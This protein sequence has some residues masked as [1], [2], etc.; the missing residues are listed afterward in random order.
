MRIIL[1]FKKKCL[2]LLFRKKYFTCTFNNFVYFDVCNLR[3]SSSYIPFRTKL[4]IK[5]SPFICFECFF[6]Y[7]P[8]QGFVCFYDFA[9][10]LEASAR[11]CRLV[12]GLYDGAAELGEPSLLPSVYTELSPGGNTAMVGA[13]QPVP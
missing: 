13:R 9:M 4:L 2:L 11:I 1:L 8:D 10:G 7:N 5:I 12:V 6:S 3:H